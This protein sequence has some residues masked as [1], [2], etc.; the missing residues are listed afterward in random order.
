M[1]RESSFSR[2]EF[3]FYE[4]APLDMQY[5]KITKLLE[6]ADLKPKTESD[7][8]KELEAEKAELENKNETLQKQVDSFTSDD[9]KKE[10]VEA[11]TRNQRY[12]ELV[13]AVF[14]KLNLDWPSS[15]TIYI[16]NLSKSIVEAIDTLKTTKTAD[17]SAGASADADAGASAGASAGTTTPAAMYLSGDAN[18][19]TSWNL[20][21]SNRSAIND[22][23]VH[24]DSDEQKTIGDIVKQTVAKYLATQEVKK[25]VA[26]T[27]LPSGIATPEVSSTD[28][29]RAVEGLLLDELL[30]SSLFDELLNTPVDLAITLAT[31]QFDDTGSL[32]KEAVL[33]KGFDMLVQ[34]EPKTSDKSTAG[35]GT[36]EHKKAYGMK[37]T[38]WNPVNLKLLHDVFSDNQVKTF[39]NFGNPED[40]LKETQLGMFRKNPLQ[41]VLQADKVTRIRETFQWVS[42]NEKFA[43]IV[44]KIKEVTDHFKSAATE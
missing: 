17:A 18:D 8:I 43:K 34:M 10:L 21:F 11:T 42:K 28:I 44:I 32:T 31:K 12:L 15:A 4:P 14:A 23:I 3:T 5:D 26:V 22:F 29:E 24:V 30:K 38:G 36:A 41:T 40:L 7:A 20:D 1:D 6:D 16:G 13:K 25:G 39:L 27:A 33:E 19:E 35:W 9:S 37:H 2:N